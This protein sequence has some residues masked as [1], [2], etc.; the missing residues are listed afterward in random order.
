MDY[1][2]KTG[3]L[4]LTE[5]TNYVLVWCFRVLWAFVC[6]LNSVFWCPLGFNLC[7]GVVRGLTVGLEPFESFRVTLKKF[8]V[9]WCYLPYGKPYKNRAEIVICHSKFVLQHADFGADDN[10]LIDSSPYTY[11]ASLNV[12]KSYKNNR[13]SSNTR[14]SVKSPAL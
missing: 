13:I 1:Q 8:F 7:I 11:V 9:F 6:I 12:Q 5:K 4:M 10:R 3:M 14:I 2:L